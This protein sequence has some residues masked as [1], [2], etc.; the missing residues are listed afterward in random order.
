M[1]RIVMAGL[2]GASVATVAQAMGMSER[3]LY[4]KAKDLGLK[5]GDVIRDVKLDYAQ[6][7]L[8]EGLAT[9][10]V[11]REV[12]YTRDYLKKLMTERA[13]P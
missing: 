10:E 4:R 11:A 7:R 1:E 12:G 5:A 8:K 3:H 6:K 2:A 13:S 9:A